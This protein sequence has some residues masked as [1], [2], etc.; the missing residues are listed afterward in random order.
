VLKP[1]LT[2]LSGEKCWYCE[3]KSKRAPFDV[4]HFRPKLGVTV[5]GVS[6]TNDFGYYWIAYAWW[7][8]RLSCQ[9][10]NRRERDGGGELRGK[11]NEFPIHVEALRCQN[12]A[13]DLTQETPRVLD[14]CVEEDC[15][16]LAHGLDGEVKPAAPHGTWEH[17]RGRYTIDLL[18]FNEW[19]LPEDRRSDWQAIAAV[20]S[21][22][23][24]P[25]PQD[26]LDVLTPY[27]S[28]N[29]EYSR[30][31]RSAIGTHRDK[32]WVEDLL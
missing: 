32:Q 1:W 30:F 10:C 25:P 19:N 21:L 13:D 4:D 24:D 29:R 26:I 5:D 20:I 16:L 15:D 8:F 11:A 14:P 3:G 27:L 7:N 12:E 22:A 17:Q 18:G 31:F 2:A 6:L 9:R 28:P 23:P